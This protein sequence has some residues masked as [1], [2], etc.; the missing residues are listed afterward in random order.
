M[1]ILNDLSSLQEEKRI[2]I[3]SQ[4]ELSIKINCEQNKNDIKI[5]EM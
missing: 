1:L 2:Q 4:K 5:H 3:K